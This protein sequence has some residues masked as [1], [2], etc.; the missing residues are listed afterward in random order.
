MKQILVFFWLLYP[1]LSIVAQPTADATIAIVNGRPISRNEFVYAYE[2][3]K[4]ISGQSSLSPQEYLN[5]YIDYQLKLSDALSLGLDTTKNFLREFHQYRDLQLSKKLV[6]PLYIDSIARTIYLKEEQQL[7]GKDLLNVSHILLTIPSTATSTQR[8]HVAQ[9]ADSLYQAIISGANFE[10]IARRFSE[11]RGTAQ[12]GGRLPTIYPGM[13]V[14][15][16]EET[17]YRLQPNQ[18]S[19]PILSPFGYHIILMRDRHPL[20]HYEELYPSL[21]QYL[22]KNHV[23]EAAANQRIAQLQAI[24]GQSRTS[25]MD[26]LMRNLSASDTQLTY[27]IKEYHDGLLV[28]EISKRKVWD[29]AE[30]SPA[31][32]AEVFKRNRKS[33]KWAQPRFVGYIIGAQNKKLAKRAQ[34]LLRKGVPANIDIRSFLYAPFNRDSVVVDAKGRYVVQEGENSTIDNLAFGVKASKVYQLHEGLP[35]TLLAGRIEKHPKTYEDVR[36]EVLELL[37]KQLEDSWLQQLRRTYTVTINQ[38]VLKSIPMAK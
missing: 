27:L 31:A 34:K 10:D 35:I 7:G 28:Y 21:L 12:E 29:A 36:S 9:R 25:I 6:S 18:V 20:Q 14:A 32:L 8:D 2:K 5:L 3:N 26:S 22:R 16:F 23:E 38:D 33:L 30:N 17:A 13:T 15:P 24:T 4:A 19:R 37:Q 11:D 1:T